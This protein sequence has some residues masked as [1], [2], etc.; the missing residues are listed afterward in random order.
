MASDPLLPV[1]LLSGTDRPKVRRALVRLR[2][3][4]G[5]EALEVLDAAESS[6]E[7][8]VAACN[9][10]GLFGAEGTRLVVVEGVERWKAEDAA[11]IAAYGAAPAPGSVL[12]LVAEEPVKS[13]A[14]AD[15]C[16]KSG[17]VLVF[18][19]PKPKDLHGW[20]RQQF[21]RLGTPIDPDAARALVEIAGDDST[22]LSA[23]IDKLAT[24]A[25]R[26][27]VSLAV[28][29]RLAVASH[30]APS[31]AVTDAWGAR[32]V[33]ALLGAC[34][35]ELERGLQPFVLASRLASQVALVRAARAL[36]DEGMPTK[37]IAKRVR[38][39]EFRVK[40]ALGHAQ[41]YS[42]EELDDATVR[43][44]ALD[45]A[46][47]GASRLTAELELSRSLLDLTARRE[48]V[49]AAR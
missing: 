20:V 10:M 1:Y 21:E 2:S 49:A 28:V 29:E 23:E 9:A 5:E 31:W 18:D 43:L 24:W 30:E 27:V 26:E 37:E 42:T 41:N 38:R 11:E 3:R 15:A 44:A 17:R 25:G 13:K 16:A 4:I 7:D 8:A 39:H 45:A 12:A 47:K 6:G 34:E 40:K 22:V 14:L 35:G 33:P 36:A 46:L 32:D 48:P 19:V